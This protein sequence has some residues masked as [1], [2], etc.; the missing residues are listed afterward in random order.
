[1]VGEKRKLAGAR[2]YDRRNDKEVVLNPDGVF[3][4]VGLKANTK[5][6]EKLVEL[7][8]RGAIKAD[9]E[10]MTSVPGIFAA[11]DCRS[12]STQQVGSAVGEGVIA[13]IRISDYLKNLK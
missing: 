5:L 1:M 10:M 7:D 3:M 13:S 11:G 2:F 8:E 9:K 4:L 12:E 6:V